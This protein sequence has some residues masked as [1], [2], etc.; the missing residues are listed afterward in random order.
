[1]Q[2][3]RAL[4][5]LM[6][7]DA[8]VQQRLDTFFNLPVTG[9]VPTVWPKVQNQVTLFG[10]DYHGNQYAPGNEHDLQAPFLYNYAG[11]PWKTQAVARGVASLFTPTPDGLPG[12]DDLGALSGWLVWTMLGIYPMTPGAPMYTIASPVFDRAVVHRPGRPDLVIDAPGASEIDKYI[13]SATLDGTTLEQ[14]W[15]TE[16]EGNRLAVQMGPLPNQAWGSTAAAVPPSLSTDASLDSFG[17][18]ADNG[19]DTEP[20]AT[21]LTYVGDT[22]GRGSSVRLAALLTDQSGSPIAGKTIV[23]EIDGQILS[24][25]TGPDGIAETT[26][27]VAGHGSSQEVT[28]DFGGDPSHLPAHTQ[29]TISWGPPA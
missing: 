5:D 2:D 20:V 18:A 1:M 27:R 11:A 8:A 14:T 15:F 19:S 24:A 29:A 23:F 4:F 13:Q 28:A 7:G 9:T 10:L 21:A 25:T 12:N 6:G 3:L 22:R 17:C 16:S 26:A